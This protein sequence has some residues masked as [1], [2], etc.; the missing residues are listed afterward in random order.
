MADAH[1]L[2]EK[3]KPDDC[4]ALINNFSCLVKAALPETLDPR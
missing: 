3:D 4:C 2:I 1:D